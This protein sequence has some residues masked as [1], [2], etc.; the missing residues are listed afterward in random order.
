MATLKNFTGSLVDSRQL[1]QWNC[2]MAVPTSLGCQEATSL[3]E[4]HENTCCWSID[5]ADNRKPAEWEHRVT[6]GTWWYGKGGGLASEGDERAERS[7]CDCC[8]QS[9]RGAF[10]QSEVV[11][12][13]N[14]KSIK[15]HVIVRVEIK[16]SCPSCKLHTRWF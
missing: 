4:E 7:S 11:R 10:S 2:E 15:S 12:G 16:I 8:C 14:G 1:L 3:I 5:V 9:W 13:D 6:D